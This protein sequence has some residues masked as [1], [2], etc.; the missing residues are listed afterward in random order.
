MPEP[1]DVVREELRNYNSQIDGEEVHLH[2]FVEFAADN[3][4]EAFPDHRFPRSLIRN[5][6]KKLHQDDEIQYIGG[7]NYRILRLDS[8]DVRED[9]PGEDKKQDVSK[10]EPCEDE[11]DPSKHDSIVDGV[12]ED[13]DL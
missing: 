3:V 13:L 8:E 12:M 10:D 1:I 11:D 4:D 7:G 5:S 6:L 2:D 9:V